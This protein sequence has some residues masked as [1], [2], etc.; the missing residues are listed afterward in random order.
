MNQ[1][2]R[3]RMTVE[4]D[5][6]RYHGFQR[7]ANANTI[8][9]EMEKAI[10]RLTGETA[11]VLGA[12][13]TDAGVH[14]LGQVIA[15][16]TSATIPVE[17]WKPAL[18]TYLPGDIRVVEAEAAD[19]CFHPQFQARRKTYEYRIYRSERGCTLQRNH[20][21]CLTISLNLDEMRKAAAYIA[22]RH[23]F[24]A[25][26]ASG[27]RVK[28]FEREVYRCELQDQWPWLTMQIEADGF[29]YNM[30]RIIIGTLLLVGQGKLGADQ[31]P[32]IIASR[33]RALAGVTAVPQGLYMLKVEY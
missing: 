33:D 2:R 32:R 13:R 4:Y 20:A 25:F 31:I 9:A 30:V 1:T 26:C 6:G 17:R 22:G 19:G 16:D 28:S 12:G 7:Q 18:N 15:F 29:L 24:S 27:S 11:T 5:G 23:D 8:Q 21:L 10:C 14:A 3:I